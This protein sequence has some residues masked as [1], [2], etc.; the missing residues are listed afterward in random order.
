MLFA[1]VNGEKIEAL[2][3]TIGKCPLC[4]RTVLS[5]CGEVNVWHWAHSKEES[6]DSWYEPESEWHKNWKFAFGK[7]NC[8]V[9]ISKEGI[10]HIADIF[11]NEGVVI[12]LQ[13]SPIQKQIIRNREIFYGER[14]IW[15]INGKPFKNNFHY[16]RS[17][18]RQLDEDEEYYLK[19]NPLAKK[20]TQARK[21]EYSFS[22]SWC[23]KSWTVALRQVFIDFGDENLFWV[24]EG[25]G[26]NNGIGKLVNKEIFIKKYGGNVELL[27]TLIDKT[28]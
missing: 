16:H 6:C 9:V 3:K 22:W 14:M 23:R 1:F 4:E 25:V 13:N 12:E 20:N 18:S 21:D 17:R 7:N 24:Q 10:R 15:V 5:K 19:Y 26:T 28:R 8:E 2:P 27:V 11:T